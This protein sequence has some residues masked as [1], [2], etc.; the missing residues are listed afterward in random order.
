MSLVVVMT[1]SENVNQLEK[2]AQAAVDRGLAACV[3]IVG[4]ITSV[5]RWQGKTESAQEFRCE[6]KTTLDNLKRLE[7]LIRELHSYELPEIIAFPVTYASEDYGRWVR[8]HTAQ[9]E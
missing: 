8:D 6:M 2:M 7:S 1:T 4:P 5:Y 9:E 3:Q